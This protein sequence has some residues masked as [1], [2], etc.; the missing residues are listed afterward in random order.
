MNQTCL[1]ELIN[2]GIC[3]GS[4]KQVVCPSHPGNRSIPKETPIRVA[5][6]TAFTHMG[7]FTRQKMREWHWVHTWGQW[8]S[9]TRYPVAYP[10]TKPGCFAHYVTRQVRHCEQC[11]LKQK[12][13][14]W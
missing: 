8:V 5:A 6:W 3:D 12:N 9:G 11:G 2:T 14:V 13:E 10:W 1:C 4:E 7:E